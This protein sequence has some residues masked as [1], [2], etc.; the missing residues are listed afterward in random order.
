MTKHTPGPWKQV[1]YDDWLYVGGE[2]M[3]FI[4]YDPV[5]EPYNYSV[6]NAV[7]VIDH[8]GSITEEGYANAHLIAAAPDLLAA[9]ERA[10]QGYKNLIEL[11]ALPHSGWDKQAREYINE[12]DALIAKTKG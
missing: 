3:D 4:E 10:R 6:E 9:C 12:L 2:K 5:N 7:C 8:V 1:E 11:G